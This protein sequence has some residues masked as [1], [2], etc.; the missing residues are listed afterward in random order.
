MILFVGS[1]ADTTLLHTLEAARKRHV[2]CDWID[3]AHVA[4]AGEASIRPDEDAAVIRAAGREWTIER[5]VPI[6]ARLSDVSAAAPTSEAATRF[7]ALYAAF[8]R[9]LTRPS[10]RAI[11]AHGADVSNLSKPFHAHFVSRLTGFRVPRTLVSNDP[12][13]LGSFVDECRDG[14]IVKGISSRKTWVRMYQRDLDDER[15]RTI[16]GEP[17]ML[18]R[19]I[20]GYDVRVHCVGEFVTAERIECEDADYRT[21]HAPRFARCDVPP[22]VRAGVA[23]LQRHTGLPMLG[24]DF[25]VTDDGVWYFLEANPMPAYQG[26]DRRCGGAIANAMLDWLLA[27]S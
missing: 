1:V 5:G 23:A 15:L 4:L 19:R 27:E 26:Y 12:D 13:A 14:V 20:A 16:H 7:R 25:R 17:V 24:I 10:L 6:Y 8:V 21:S 3:L 18:Q 9:L 2:T 22:K 11:H